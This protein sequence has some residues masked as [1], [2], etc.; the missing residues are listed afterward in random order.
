MPNETVGPALSAEQNI[1]PV[2][3]FFNV[4][5]TFNTFIGQGQP[6][7]VTGTQTLSIVNT[8]VNATLYPTLSAII[9]GTVTALSVNS[10]NFSYNP[11]T[12]TLTAPNFVGTLTGN[13][14]TA[15]NISG[16]LT[17]EIP[18][19]IS[20]NQT[21]FIGTGL[22]G[23][24]LTSNGSSAPSFQTVTGGVTIASTAGAT[25]YYP[26]L[27][28]GVGPVSTQYI[29][30]SA[31]SFQSGV[32]TGVFSGD[33]SGG[34]GSFSTLTGS[35]AVTLNTTSNNQSY[36]TTG[37]ATITLSS[38]TTGSINNMSIGATTASSG[39]FTTVS[40][41]SQITS[42][43]STGTAPFVIA[44]TTPVANLSI[45][46][47]AG[48][49]TTATTASNVAVST[50]ASASPFYPALVSATTGASLPIN[51]NASLSYVPSTGQLSATSYLGAWQGSAI[52]A[53]Y[54]GT[55]LTSYATGDIIYAS[56]TNTLSKLTAGT[57]G[58]VLTLSS[59]VPTWAA[60]TGGVTS[61]SAGTTGFS[62]NTASTG[63]IVLSGTLNAVNGGTQQSTYAT[64][65]ILYA[66]AAN[67]LSKLSAGANGNVL[68]LAAGVPTWAASTGGVTSFQTSLSGLTPN[69]SSTGAITLA[70]TL[71][72][73]S[74]GT[75]L[76][77]VGTA[78]N[79]LTS[80]GTTW[81]SQAPAP[82][83]AA[84][85]RTSFT[86]TV[87]QTTFSVSYTAPY[88]EVYQ[89]GTLLNASDY[90]ASNGT[91]VVLTIGAST[92]DIIETIA[93][94]VSIGGGGSPGGSDTQIQ[95]NNSGAFA[96]NANFTYTGNDVNIPF[97]PS[98]SAT[99]ASR[100]ALAISMMT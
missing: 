33:I 26:T 66:S 94:S 79:I 56:G 24:V 31:L 54:G 63:A 40:A 59:G 38:G 15:T 30:T 18:Y 23:Q 61:F 71:G 45:G 6:F 49:A 46:G 9:N 17:S 53:I 72:A 92:G 14:T 25:T 82:T 12:G 20:P 44:S 98:N 22:A 93:Y 65:D 36:T 86:A 95:Y 41:S 47:N 77:S 37:A 87:G 11:S 64:G 69:T 83:T 74:G 58:Y 4:D 7:S 75:G 90:T 67:T 10:V 68:T 81:V 84:Y 34:T 91:T 32:L 2:Q 8:N 21:G 60:S 28:T 13:S 16:G 48:T 5:G 89:N 29:N 96:G 39:A 70:G 100:V 57:N 80:N 99:S 76:T 19:Q 85:V 27:A 97:G 78:G 88:I 55:G 43:V 51:A 3:A 42:T 1:L 50:T 35:G 62:P 52:G 73:T